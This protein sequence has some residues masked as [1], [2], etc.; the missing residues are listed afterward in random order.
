MKKGLLSLFAFV[1]LITVL[2]YFGTY[3]PAPLEEQRLNSPSHAPILQPGQTLKIM[4]WNIQ[5]MAG[6]TNN[7]YF[8]AGGDDPWAS[9]DVM[10][11]TLEDVVRIIR[12]ENPDILLLQEVD[13]GAVRT[14]KEDQLKKILERLPEEYGSYASAFYWKTAFVP[15]PS[16]M[17]SMGMK[18][19][20]VS[21]YKISKATRH[22]LASITDQNFITRQLS[23]KRA[24]LDV[25]FPVAGGKSLTAFNT[26]LSAFAQDSDTMARQVEQVAD[27][28]ARI[29]T[30]GQYGFVAG[31]FNLIP[32]GA[33]A[34]L[35]KKIQ[36]Y[37]NPAGTEIE[38][39]Y[40]DYHPVPTL[41]EI[42]SP[43]FAQWFTAMSTSG[44]QRNPDKTID[45]I[46]F[47]KPL[48]PGEHYIRTEDTIS[49]SDHLPVIA[50]FTLPK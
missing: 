20:T 5:F 37:Y 18:L 41:E 33:Y 4:S 24:L 48:L 42:S 26:H 39:L 11:Q 46:I 13:D 10:N 34:N 27:Q 29:E 16:I 2:F 47:A 19:S 45:Y 14:F 17:G 28:L 35:S 31:D 3:H 32:P 21:K 50:Y 1:L 38:R 12:D 36:A 22:A 23:I 44:Q 40:D 8:Y 49:V 30:E 43:D 9:R 25:Q 15:H 7:H 6:N